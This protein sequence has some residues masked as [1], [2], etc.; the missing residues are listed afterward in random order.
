VRQVQRH[1]QGAVSI[2]PAFVAV[3]ARHGAAAVGRKLRVSEAAVRSWK[4]GSRKPSPVARAAM[5]A[6]YGVTA[7]S[8]EAEAGPAGDGDVAPPST[9]AQ[10]APPSRTPR[11]VALPL[12]ADPGP[13]SEP[14]FALPAADAKATASATVRRLER[15]LDRLDGDV[16]ATARERA[17]VASSLTSATRLLAKLSGAL[18]VTKSQ[19]L[20]SPVWES[21][22]VAIVESLAPWPDA[23]IAVAKALRK[24]EGDA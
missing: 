6:A 7:G 13:T 23:S 21:M 3:V 1:G 19:I 18:D 20:R 4:T 8:W 5:E 10:N 9:I 12:K 15:E 17:S 16:L 11:E 22:T 24:L 2:N 14:A